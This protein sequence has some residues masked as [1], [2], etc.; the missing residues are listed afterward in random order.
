MQYFVLQDVMNLS[1]KQ[2]KQKVN[3]ASEFDF[4]IAF[5]Y[6]FLQL[7]LQGRCLFKFHINCLFS[8]FPILSH[9]LPFTPFWPA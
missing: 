8:F 6:F 4:M 5:I 3:N 9:F 1:V 7:N 2:Q